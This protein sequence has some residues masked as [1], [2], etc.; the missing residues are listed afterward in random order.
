M[1]VKPEGIR[2]IVF[3]GGQPGIHASKTSHVSLINGDQIPGT[4]TSLDDKQL[5][6]SSPIVGEITIPR[7]QL[8]SLSPNPFDGKLSYAGPFTSE[9]WVMLTYPEVK[10][11]GDEVEEEE[12]E[13]KIEEESQPDWVYSGAAFFNARDQAPLALKTNLPKTG[14]LQFDVSWKGRLNLQI[15]LHADYTRPIIPEIEA[16]EEKPKEADKEAGTTRNTLGP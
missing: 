6:L 13:E 2:Q 3:N 8:K 9:G 5:V 7:D 16:E 11:A 15:A 10:K 14:R 12:E 4:I 1:R